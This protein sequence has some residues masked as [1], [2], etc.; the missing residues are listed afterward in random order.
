MNR[1]VDVEVGSEKGRGRK[2]T[3]I[4]DIQDEAEEQSRS[5]LSRLFVVATSNPCC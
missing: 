1:G 3:F 4:V 2:K 5:A